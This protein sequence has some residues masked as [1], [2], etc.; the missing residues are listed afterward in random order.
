MNCADPTRIYLAPPLLHVVRMGA[1][2]V[3]STNVLLLLCE[4]NVSRRQQTRL[5]LLLHVSQGQKAGA[6]C[7]APYRL[8]YSLLYSCAGNGAKRVRHC[9]VPS[10]RLL[11]LLL[12]LQSCEYSQRPAGLKVKSSHFSRRHTD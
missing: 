11:L 9:A 3:C 5:P 7:P 4:S 2:Y 12:L 8:L 6:D 10:C 1:L